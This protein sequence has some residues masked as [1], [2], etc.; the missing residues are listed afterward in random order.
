MSDEEVSASGAP[1]QAGIAQRFHVNIP[2]PAKLDVRGNLASNWKKFRRMWNNYEIASRLQNESKEL[3]TATLLSCIGSEAFETYEGLEWANE[4]EK[5]DIDV[6]LEKFETLLCRGYEYYLRA[7]QFQPT[8]TGAKRVFRSVRC[9][10]K[11][12]G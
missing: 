5:A 10:V 4:D 8:N 2:L 9:C 12:S 3:R 6:V 1:R 11:S 7:V